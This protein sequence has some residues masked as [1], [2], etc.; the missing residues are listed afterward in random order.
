[1][2]S[3][4]FILSISQRGMVIPFAGQYSF[5]AVYLFVRENIEQQLGVKGQR[6]FPFLLTLFLFILFSNLIGLTPYAFAITSQMIVNFTLSFTILIA[7]TVL[8]I[9][10]QKADFFNLFFPS[11]VQKALLV[12]LFFIEVVSYLTRGFSLAIRLFANIMAGHTLLAI[13]TTFVIQLG[14]FK[15]YL[16]LLTLIIV[17]MVLVLEFVIAFVQAYVFFI[18]TLIYLHDAFYSAH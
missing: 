17:M 9:V 15:L 3:F 2:R 10:H 16:G 6:F 11:G 14:K 7:I 5:E 4:A 13:L 1:M 8:G 12:L 18:L